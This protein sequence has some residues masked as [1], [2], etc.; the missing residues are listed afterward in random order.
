MRTVADDLIAYLS[1]ISNWCTHEV[2]GRT[3][4]L[5]CEHFS[6]T[7]VIHEE[8]IEVRSINTHGQHGFGRRILELVHAIADDY[9]LS[10][11]AS[12]VRTTARGFWDAMGYTEGCAGEFFR[13]E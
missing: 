5:E 9:G 7:F 2:C 6:L 1:A 12:N 8:S 13:S 4:E 11:Y 3:H 10:V